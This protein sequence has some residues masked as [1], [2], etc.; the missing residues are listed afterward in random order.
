MTELINAACS[1][2]KHVPVLIRLE[3]I[4]IPADFPEAEESWPG[5][6]IVNR[7]STGRDVPLFSVS[8]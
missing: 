8:E 7:D 3:S 6:A 4:L 5:A 2:I 1:C